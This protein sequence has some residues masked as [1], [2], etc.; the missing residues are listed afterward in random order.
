MYYTIPSDDKSEAVRCICFPKFLGIAGSEPIS[1]TKIK[2]HHE[3]LLAKFKSLEDVGE[4][5]SFIDRAKN[6]LIWAKSLEGPRPSV[7]HDCEEVKKI[8]RRLKQA[9]SQNK[10]TVQ[11]QQTYPGGEPNTIGSPRQQDESTTK[12]VANQWSPQQVWTTEDLG[13]NTEISHRIY[14]SFKQ[15]VDAYQDHR[16]TKVG[17]IFKTSWRGYNPDMVSS[18]ES[19]ESA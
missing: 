4:I 19:F 10:V 11:G 2:L 8:L 13:R 18:W 14:G 5:I 17:T 15:D 16:Y 9:H 3:K 12:D 1:E 7:N 6:Y